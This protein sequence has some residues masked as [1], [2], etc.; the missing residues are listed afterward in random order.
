MKTLIVLPAY[1]E[2]KVLANTLESLLKSMD[3]F[4]LVV[5]DGSADNTTGIAAKYAKNKVKTVRHIINLGLGAAVETGLEYA[6]R[7]DFD[8]LVTFDADGQHNPKDIKRL[9]KSLQGS[10]VVI[11]VRELHRDRM[12]FIKKVGNHCLNLLTW[13]S[14]GVYSRDSQSGLRAFNREAISAIRLRA[15]HYEA[16]SEILYEAA[17]NGLRV[18]EVPVDVIYT[19]HSITKGTNIF[20]GFKILWGI[21][22]HKRG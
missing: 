14:F 1:N 3:A 15:R 12:P 11:G 22:L 6:R 17:R 10:D 20:D 2:S 21:L 13:A 8:V 4:I 18:V 16:S 9:I 19:E 5:D 7:G